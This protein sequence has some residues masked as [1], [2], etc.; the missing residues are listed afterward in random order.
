MLS[1][2][3]QN[4][5]CNGQDTL[6]YSQSVPLRFTDALA[7][8]RPVVEENHMYIRIASNA[9][10]SASQEVVSGMITGEYSA[11]QAYTAFDSRLRASEE[12][13]EET[14]LTVERTYSN[15][16]CP[17]G[18]NEGNSVMANTLRGIYGTDV[19]IATGDSFTGSVLQA[20][21][22]KRMA[23]SMIMPNGLM[24]YRG[25]MSGAELKETVRAFVEGCEGGFTPFNRGALPTVSG[26]AM[27]VTEDKGTYTLKALT[28]GG[29]AIGDGDMFSVTCLATA[30]HMAPLLAKEGCV[31]EEDGIAVKETWTK[32]I[33]EGNAALACPENYITL[34]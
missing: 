1:A 33:T 15:T 24:A 14:V 10:F 5:I 7:D 13:A 19:L 8:V 26:I 34:R 20:D 30:K 18:G 12:T 6:S 29:K 28:K 27:E 25:K 3:A 32:Y 23:R 17:E 11:A 21:Y 2:E 9:F 31:F 22:T 16:F 4:I